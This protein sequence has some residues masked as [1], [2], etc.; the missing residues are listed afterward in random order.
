MAGNLD[1]FASPRAVLAL[2]LV[3][4]ILPS[5][6]GSSSSILSSQTNL[7]LM[8]MSATQHFSNRKADTEPKPFKNDVNNVAALQ[9]ARLQ[10]RRMEEAA[11]LQQKLLN[12]TAEK[13]SNQVVDTGI[14]KQELEDVRKLKDILTQTVDHMSVELNKSKDDLARAMTANQETHDQMEEWK[15]LKNGELT[16]KNME[17]EGLRR[18]KDGE[19]ASKNKELENKNIEL[20]KKNIELEKKNVEL[21]NK[22]RELNKVKD[23]K[24]QVR[25]LYYELD[26]E[27]TRLRRQVPFKDQRNC[28]P[29]QYH[30]STVL[31]INVRSTLAIDLGK[32]K[33]G[34][35]PCAASHGKD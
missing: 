20:E 33:S 24:K 32:G 12:E 3:S 28:L 30:N 17:M 23:E 1:Q 18:L 13:L 15:R 16:S 14:V 35:L 9:S 21:E 10:K 34:P 27:A 2:V 26:N 11:L 31:I 8:A 7:P 25:D 6:Y 5:S 22:N 4:P 29:A 19:L